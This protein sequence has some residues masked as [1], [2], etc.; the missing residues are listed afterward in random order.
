MTRPSRPPLGRRADP[1]II[2]TRHRTRR[3]TQ[4]V[5]DLVYIDE[6][7][8]VGKGAG[9]QPLL[10]LTAVVVHEDK[11]QPLAAAFRKLAWKHLAWLPADFDVH[12]NAIWNGTS[13][14]EGKTAPEIIAIYEDAISALDQFEIDVSYAIIDKQRLHDRYGGGAI[15]MPTSSLSSSCSRSSSAPTPATR[16]LSRMSRRSTSSERSRWWP[17]SRAGEAAKY[18]ERS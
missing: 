12:G 5:A 15:R 18:R 6:T 3:F 16:S 2:G 13:H 7:G 11:V 14:R 8:S 17:I 10:T 1:Q 9:K 4:T